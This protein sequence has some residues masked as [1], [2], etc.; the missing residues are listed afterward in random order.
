MQQAHKKDYGSALDMHYLGCAMYMIDHLD[1][2]DEKCHEEAALVWNHLKSILSVVEDFG[3][4]RQADLQFQRGK[5]LSESL[6][7]TRARDEALYCGGHISDN[8]ENSTDDKKKKKKKKKK[9]I[10]SEDS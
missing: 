8:N 1:T 5:I 10:Q 7:E 9:K 6:V 3:Q 4:C 2:L